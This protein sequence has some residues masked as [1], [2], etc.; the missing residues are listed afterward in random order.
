MNPPRIENVRGWHC[1]I[2]LMNGEFV[3]GRA[4]QSTPAEITLEEE[5]PPYPG[6]DTSHKIAWSF[7]K[8]VTMTRPVSTEEV[9]E[10]LKERLPDVE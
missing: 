4:M 6:V 7:V 8:R 5:D 2:E 9:V 3:R 10:A 1:T